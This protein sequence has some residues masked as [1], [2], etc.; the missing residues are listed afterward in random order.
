MLLVGIKNC[1]TLKF[2]DVFIHE[3]SFEESEFSLTLRVP[4]IF[5]D[6]PIHL[7]KIFFGFTERI[8]RTFL[9]YLV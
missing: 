7:R 2:D 9:P 3:A 1:N 4:H 5:V 6:D 8:P